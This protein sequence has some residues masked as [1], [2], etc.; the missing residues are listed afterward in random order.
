[1]VEVLFHGVLRDGER[2]VVVRIVTRRVA[3]VDSVGGANAVGR[4]WRRFVV[5][6]ALAVAMVEVLFHGVLWD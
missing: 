4:T 1:M 6:D 5:T 2:A 3:D